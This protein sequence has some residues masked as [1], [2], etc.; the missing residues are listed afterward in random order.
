MPGS[1]RA[2]DMNGD[3]KIDDDDRVALGS[4][5]PDFTWGLT[6][7]LRYKNFDLSFLFQGVHGMEIF[8][9][10]GYYTEMRKF[11][12]FFTENRYVNEMYPGDGKTPI[13]KGG[14]DRMF[15]DYL[16]EDASFIIL[17]NAN[18]GYTL[19]VSLMQRI[20][21][22]GLRIYASG[23]NLLLFTAKGYRGI[24]PESVD[25]GDNYDSPLKTGAQRGAQP[26]P[27]TIVFGID[28]TF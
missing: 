17:R 16:I 5:F 13:M 27:R 7:E 2:I 1:S 15:T 22:K 23:Q 19:P 11:N 18:I 3:D 10:D 9:A 24:N 12:R 21:V 8:N 26:I 28:L 4:P 14:I 6:N 20:K 25:T